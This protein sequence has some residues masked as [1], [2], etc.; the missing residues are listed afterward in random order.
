[1]TITRDEL[2][3]NFSHLDDADIDLLHGILADDVEPDF[4]TA[5]DDWIRQCFHRPSDNE[6][7]MH[8]VDTVLEGFGVEA[9]DLDSDDFR[10]GPAAV[11]S[12][13][14]DTYDATVV[15]LRDADEY[16]VSTWGDVFESLEES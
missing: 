13:Q 8:A 2:T 11:Y 1:M 15:Y 3:D 5:T 10:S 7:K 14:G 12:N 6:L 4:V 9:I 16:I